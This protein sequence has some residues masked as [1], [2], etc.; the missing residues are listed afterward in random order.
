VYLKFYGLVEKPFNMTPD[1]R[2]LYLTAGH[3]EAL[4][5]LTYAVREGQGFMVLT[6][7]VGTGKTTLIRTLLEQLEGNTAAAVVVN[8]TLPF[9]GILEY[10]LED[11]GVSK[12]GATQA[13]RLFALN[14]FLIERHRAGQKSVIII[15]E[16]Q[17]LAPATLE[18]VRLLSNFQAARATL[19]QILLVGQPELR[20]RLDLPEL[21]QLK[22]RI[23]L[24][25]TIGPLAA[26]EVGAYLR[27]RLRAAGARDLDLFTDRAVTRIAQYSAGIPR[28]INAL[29]EHC[30]VLGYAEQRRRLDR[31]IVD[32]AIAYLEAGAQP[33]RPSGRRETGRWRPRWAVAGA[34]ALLGVG[35]VAV[36]L[37]TRA[38]E[39]IPAPVLAHL[40]D[41]VEAVRGAFR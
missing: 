29:G 18:Q 7:D 24:R 26:E 5:Q 27:V 39:G 6:G 30:L 37:A 40:G 2:F 32:E 28:V 34:T 13:Q 17:H 23:A 14:S 1:P 3:R 36:T 8:P 9:D 25:C 33:A 20:A 12:A 19:L 10:V 16:A 11:F 38:W 22:Q 21:R 15:D 4:A 41:L 35:V 31:D